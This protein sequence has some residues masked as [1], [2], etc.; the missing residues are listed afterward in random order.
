MNNFRLF[1]VLCA[2]YVSLV[3]TSIHASL[4]DRENGLIYDTDMD[5]T[6][7]QDAFAFGDPTVRPHLLSR[8]LMSRDT[9][10]SWVDA[11]DFGG[12]DDWRL[13]KTPNID[14]SCG[15]DATDKQWLTLTPCSG[16]EMGHLFYS[17]LLTYTLSAEN[18]SLGSL[19]MFEDVYG[20]GYWTSEDYLWTGQT[21]EDP[22]GTLPTDEKPYPRTPREDAGWAFYFGGDPGAHK[23]LLSTT[24][25]R[26]VW[27]VRDGDVLAAAVPLPGAVWLFG[28]GLLGL[29]GF[30]RRKAGR[31]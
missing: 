1:S 6:W 19:G 12:F 26:A 11:L 5:I 9:A 28:S 10:M 31:G 24:T 21:Y 15:T 25:G 8:E 22:E 3:S 14:S 27:A 4:I 30:A 2:G 23:T 13:P 20:G 17:E 29:V 16:G 7:M 18:R